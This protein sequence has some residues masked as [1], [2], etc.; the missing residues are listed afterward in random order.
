ME[1]KTVW[2][3]RTEEWIKQNPGKGTM[4]KS[5]LTNKVPGES[6]AALVSDKRTRHKKDQK[7]IDL[8]DRGI[9][10]VICEATK[11]AYIGQSASMNVRMRSHKACIIGQVNGKSKAY[12]KMN[13]H[14]KLH[15]IDAFSFTRHLFLP[16]V[17]DEELTNIETS[18]MHEFAGMGYTLYNISIPGNIYC[19]L[20]LKILMCQIITL[21][22]NEDFIVKLRALTEYHSHIT[23]L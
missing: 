9:Y 22:K 5:E 10:A 2:L 19:P 12:I 13:E 7:T 18:T 16:N 23:N 6:L 11:Y 15:G 20:E 17:N 3:K 8:G 21:A 4:Y 1:N 14:C